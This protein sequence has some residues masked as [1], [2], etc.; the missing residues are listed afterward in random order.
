MM[1][2]KGLNYKHLLQVYFP[3]KI[4]L[5]LGNKPSC[6]IIFCIKSLMQMMSV[7][8]NDSSLKTLITKTFLYKKVHKNN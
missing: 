7:L 6:L 4:F 5:F 1:Q 3:R 8:N 2:N